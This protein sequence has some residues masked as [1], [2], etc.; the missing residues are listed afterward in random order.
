MD[1]PLQGMPSEVTSPSSAWPPSKDDKLD[2]D[3]KWFRP[4]NSTV[5]F[6]SEA[7]SSLCSRCRRRHSLRCLVT[8][9]PS[10][11]ICEKLCDIFFS[12]IFPLMP[13]IHLP[14]FA[15]DFQALWAESGST[16]QHDAEMG[17]LLQ[18]KPSFI[19]LLSSILFAS[20]VSSSQSKLSSI[21]KKDQDLAPGRIYFIVSAS[22][23]LT[24]FPRHP[25][26]DALTAYLVVQSQ[27]VREEDFSNAPDFI[28]TAFRIALGMG[29]HRQIP[30]S[31][32]SVAEIETRRRLWWYILH[33][34][35]MSSAS[36]GLSPLFIDEKMANTPK[37]SLYDAIE[38]N[39]D[40]GPR[41]N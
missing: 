12:S 24:G 32:F 6:W 23:T 34:D 13:L 4:P 27:F 31:H 41:K 14:S 39:P 8:L 1:R 35:I 29:L 16:I 3:N 25:S 26:L 18:K 30:S 11:E 37:I 17:S 2:W 7:A 40:S 21:S 28:S 5:H 33:L 36:S 38:G 22:A 15:R 10:K 20:I 19:C 9:L